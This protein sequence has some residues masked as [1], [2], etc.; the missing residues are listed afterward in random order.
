MMKPTA[1]FGCNRCHQRRA[2]HLYVLP[3]PFAK[4]RAGRINTYIVCDQ[5]ESYFLS[6]RPMPTRA[7]RTVGPAQ[8]AAENARGS[9][10]IAG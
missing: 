2:K 10:V 9:V 8:N 3:T 5:C 4:A 1:E 7:D 6:G